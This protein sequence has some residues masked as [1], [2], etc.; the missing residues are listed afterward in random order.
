MKARYVFRLIL[1]TLAAIG[2][3]IRLWAY[4]NGGPGLPEDMTIEMAARGGSWYAV[5]E[6][7]CLHQVYHALKD[8]FA[9]KRIECARL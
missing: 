3:A 1:F 7:V 4:W 9:P 6:I 2:I 5:L 8:L